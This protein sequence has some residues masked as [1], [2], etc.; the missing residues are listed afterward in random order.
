MGI[1]VLKG[2]CKLR[3][4]TCFCSSPETPYRPICAICQQKKPLDYT[5]YLHTLRGEDLQIS[6]A[7]KDQMEFR[8]MTFKMRSSYRDVRGR[9]IA[10]IDQG[11]ES[12]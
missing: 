10:G 2:S 6:D 9:L 3:M 1:N 12:I 11:M 7:L 4:K 5:F 8:D